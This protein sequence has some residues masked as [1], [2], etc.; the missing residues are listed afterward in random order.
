MDE[1]VTPTTNADNMISHAAT[2]VTEV[3][4]LASI[5]GWVTSNTL[6]AIFGLMV[7]ILGFMVNL[8]FQSRRDR[9]EAQLHDAKMKLLLKTTGQR[10]V[11]VDAIEK[12][13]GT[14]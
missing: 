10:E 11:S 7:A 14:D 8:Y 9:R 6:V 2:K 5:G 1:P 12:V 3:G 4:A 13:T